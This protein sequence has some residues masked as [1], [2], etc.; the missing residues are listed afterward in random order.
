MKHATKTRP[1]PPNRRRK[2]PYLPLLSRR[3]KNF[4][5]LATFNFLSA[6]DEVFTQDG[7]RLEKIP[8]LFDY[9]GNLFFNFDDRRKFSLV[10]LNKRLR[11]AKTIERTR[12]D[13]APVALRNLHF[14][15]L[16]NE[17]AA[18]RALVLVCKLEFGWVSFGESKDVEPGYFDLREEQVGND[19]SLEEASDAFDESWLDQIAASTGS[20]AL[21]SVEDIYVQRQHA[22]HLESP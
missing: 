13:E 2:R 8:R 14:D 10:V 18:A 19:G 12:R 3:T 17:L 7:S 20:Q 5:V 6:V 1:R 11:Q 21:A 22:T 9:V 15:A 16:A 4:A